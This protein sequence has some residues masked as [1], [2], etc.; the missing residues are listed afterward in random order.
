M[1]VSL[2]VWGFRSAVVCCHLGDE[3][4]SPKSTQEDV[5]VVGLVTA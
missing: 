4:T 3:R 1:A 2:S 5:V